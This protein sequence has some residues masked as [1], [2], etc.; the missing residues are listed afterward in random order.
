MPELLPPKLREEIVWFLTPLREFK[1]PQERI[2]LIDPCLTGW[3]G[4]H[5]LDWSGAPH[6]FFERLVRKAPAPQLERLLKSLHLGEEG[7]RQ[8]ANLC[9][10]VAQA[11]AVV[12]EADNQTDGERP[13][14]V[15]PFAGYYQQ[16]AQRLS[17]PRYQ[18]DSRFV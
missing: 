4:R 17:S 16:T 7:Q 11:L 10:R 12:A 3:N 1:L 2:D 5:N 9:Q 15:R 13:F 14:A 18:L 8:A 6:P